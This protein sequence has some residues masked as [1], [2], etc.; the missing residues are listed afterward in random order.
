MFSRRQQQQQMFCTPRVETGDHVQRKRLSSL[1]CC[2]QI[3]THSHTQPVYHCYTHA[4][5]RCPH[6]VQLLQLGAV[7]H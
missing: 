1:S 5:D 2:Q 4:V 6:L 3:I 7:Q